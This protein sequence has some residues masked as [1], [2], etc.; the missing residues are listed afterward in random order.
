MSSQKNV[1]GGPVASCSEEPLTGF[2]RTGCCDTS[3]EDVGSHTICTLLTAEF[4][5]FS[6][7]QGN[8]LSTPR[9]EF[10]FPG[11]QPGDRWCIC[12]ARWKEALQ[13][14]VAP[15]VVLSATNEAAL[16]I[17]TFEE[18]KPYALDPVVF[19]IHPASRNGVGH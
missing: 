1:L 13:A 17:V 8:D 16:E 10:G 5:A 7:S 6:H 12:A 3:V 18:L 11:L 19:N 9:L 15:P 2:F 14:G 4:L